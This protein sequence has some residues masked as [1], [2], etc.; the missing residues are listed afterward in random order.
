MRIA[1]VSDAWRPQINGVVTTLVQT[2]RAMLRDSLQA[3]L[4]RQ[5]GALLA[6][7][8]FEDFKKRLD[9]SEFGGAPLLGV[10]GVC[11]VAHGSSNAK[12]MKNAIRV[13]AET[14]QGRINP[15]IEKEIAAVKVA[16]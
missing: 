16:E 10:K 12:A 2:V 6:R 3:T 13:A 1:I 14:A 5:L 11:I 15:I 7:R 4:T 8:A 9:Y